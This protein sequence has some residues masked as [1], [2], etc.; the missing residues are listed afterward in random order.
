MWLMVSAFY[1]AFITVSMSKLRSP[2]IYGE[3]LRT[4]KCLPVTSSS[5]GIIPTC[6]DISFRYL[7][8]AFQT[9]IQSR[10]FEGK[11][12]S[13]RFHGYKINSDIGQLYVLYL[14]NKTWC[15]KN[16]LDTIK[17][18]SYKEEKKSYKYFLLIGISKWTWKQRSCELHV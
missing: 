1:I 6:S 11:A 2:N 7:Y 12:S 3:M 5:L 18:E 8:F 4:Y 16:C 9:N 14:E 13:Q 17:K 10:M 15:P